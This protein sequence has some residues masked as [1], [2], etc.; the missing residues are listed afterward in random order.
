MRKFVDRGCLFH[1]Q[2]AANNCLTLSIGNVTKETDIT[3]PVGFHNSMDKQQKKAAVQVRSNVYNNF[4]IISAA[5]ATHL[6]SVE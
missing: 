3:V 6:N 1:F 5:N 2:D 4:T